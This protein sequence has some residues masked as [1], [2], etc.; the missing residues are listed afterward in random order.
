MVAVERELPV[1]AA[2]P[3]SADA[4]PPR[5]RRTGGTPRQVLAVALIG[6]LVLG[7]FASR[8]LSSWLQ[9][10]GGGWG[11]VPLQHAAAEWNGAMT[12]LGLAAPFVALRHE[13]HR[14]LD[15]EWPSRAG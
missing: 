14:L 4:I 11:L 15:A 1:V 5:L 12:R 13:V 2:P 7:I 6:S 9:R 3:P 10:M 8:D